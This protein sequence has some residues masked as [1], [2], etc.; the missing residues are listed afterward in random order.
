M[1][2]VAEVTFTFGRWSLLLLASRNLSE[3]VWQLIPVVLAGMGGHMLAAG[4]QKLLRSHCKDF[5]FQPMLPT[6]WV[7]ALH[8]IK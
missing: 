6:S 1:L 5:A 2:H 4:K 8:S 7:T 3:R